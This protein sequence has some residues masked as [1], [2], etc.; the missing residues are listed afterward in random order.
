VPDLEDE[1]VRTEL[2]EMDNRRCG[3]GAGEWSGEVGLVEVVD[4]WRRSE[5]WTGASEMGR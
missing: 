5:D 1:R 2:D 4:G 3:R